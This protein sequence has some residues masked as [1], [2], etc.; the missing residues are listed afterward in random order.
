MN[1]NDAKTIV[2][3]LNV[4]AKVLA[5]H[6]EDINDSIVTGVETDSD[7]VCEPNFYI[8]RLEEF[9]EIGVEYVIRDSTFETWPYEFVAVMDGIEIRCSTDRAALERCNIAIPEWR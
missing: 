3:A 7:P 6:S 1:M 4:I 9:L 5:G 2:D 8:S